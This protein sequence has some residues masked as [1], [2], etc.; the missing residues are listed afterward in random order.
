MRLGKLYVWNDFVA[1][2]IKIFKCGIRSLHVNRECE[3][4]GGSL[5]G[6]LYQL[7][8]RSATIELN[9]HSMSLGCE[10]EIFV[11]AVTVAQHYKV[12]VNIA[13]ICFWR[14]GQLEIV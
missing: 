13:I 10:G 1:Y 14:C 9:I 3:I 6:Q 2:Q 5:E 4:K 11:L 7:Y 12:H 8:R